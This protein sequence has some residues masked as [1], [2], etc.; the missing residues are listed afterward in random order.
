MGTSMWW[1]AGMAL[2]GD[3]VGGSGGLEVEVELAVSQVG[4][5]KAA[6]DATRSAALKA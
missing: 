4:E 1:A 3:E 6:P 2:S 5:L